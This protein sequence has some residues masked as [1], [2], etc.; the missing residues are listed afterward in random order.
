MPGRCSSP[1]L[2]FVHL[3]PVAFHPSLPA[4]RFP[5]VDCRPSLVAHILSLVGFSLPDSGLSLA[6]AG[7]HFST[8]GCRFPPDAQ[9]SWLG[10]R[11]LWAVAFQSSP[12]ASERQVRPREPGHGSIL[13]RASFAARKKS[14]PPISTGSGLFQIP[15]SLRPRQIPRTLLRHA[16]ARG[17]LISSRFFAPLAAWRVCVSTCEKPT[18]AHKLSG[19]ISNHSTKRHFARFTRPAKSAPSR[20]RYRLGRL[21]LYCKSTGSTY[22]ACCPCTRVRKHRDRQRFVAA[23]KTSDRHRQRRGG[24]LSSRPLPRSAPSPHSKTGSDNP[25]TARIA[26]STG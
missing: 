25:R 8:S 6:R 9:C 23:P 4:R 17:G 1:G 2:R 18:F 3:L 19:R 10:A 26:A 12:T 14:P 16:R 7:G 11:G 22:S 5:P 24:L 15:E 13:R 20:G 21:L